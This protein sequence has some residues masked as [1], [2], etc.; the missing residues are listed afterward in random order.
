[1]PGAPGGAGPNDRGTPP[2]PGGGSGRAPGGG[3]G[4]GDGELTADQRRIIEYAVAHAPAARIKLAVEGGALNASAFIL[5]TDQTVI[6]MGGFTNSDNAPSTAQLEKWTENGQL[7]Y[8]LGS[9]TNGG[10]MPGLAGGYTEQRSD[11][12]ADHCTKVPA[13]AYGGASGA[14]SPDNGG[15]A[16]GFAGGSVL[17]DCAAE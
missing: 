2:F 6:A 5:G 11:W 7:R 15:G 14:S 12:I 8:I 1:M 13:S 9:D 4:F 3:G 16:T 10:G 17:Y